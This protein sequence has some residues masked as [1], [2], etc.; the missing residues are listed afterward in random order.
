MRIVVVLLIAILGGVLSIGL[1]GVLKFGGNA[2]RQHY[3][4]KYLLWRSGT[5]PW[6]CIRFLEEATERILLRRVGGGYRFIHPLLQDYFASLGTEA[7][8]NAQLQPS[9]SQP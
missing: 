6:S 5:M 1:S 2:Y 7:S 4:L 9:S 3:I 8:P